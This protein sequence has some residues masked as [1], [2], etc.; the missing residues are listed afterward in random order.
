MNAAVYLIVGVAL[1]AFASWR[2]LAGL[3]VLDMIHRRVRGHDLFVRFAPRWTRGPA[4]GEA[5]A[6]IVGG[7]IFA[8]GGVLALTNAF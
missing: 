6:D 7:L 1:L 4:G 2:I 5:L 3:Y 8:A